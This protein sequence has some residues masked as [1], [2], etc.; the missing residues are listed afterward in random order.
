MH[1]QQPDRESFWS[2]GRKWLPWCLGIVLVL[3]VGW[4]AFI[5]VH[6]VSSGKHQGLSEIVIAVVHGSAPAVSFIVLNAILLV[7]VLDVLGGLTVVTYRYLSRKFLVPLEERLQ[8]EVREKGREEGRE[9]ERRLW[10]D[11]NRR[12]EEAEQNGEPFADPPPST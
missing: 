3:D 12:R 8:Q 2:V 7:S 10:A 9:E 6:E 1:D 4:T 5:A 11:W